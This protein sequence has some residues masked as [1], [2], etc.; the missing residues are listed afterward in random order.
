MLREI[1]RWPDDG[2]LRGPV[3]ET[4]R[5]IGEVELP[6]LNGDFGVNHLEMTDKAEQTG[7]RRF[8]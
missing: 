7:P 3:G 8:R 2:Y 4:C 6:W 5:G 1:D